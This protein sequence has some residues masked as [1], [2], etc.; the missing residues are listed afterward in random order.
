[1]ATTYG[2]NARKQIP[3]ITYPVT[4]VNV[5]EQ[6]GRLRVIYDN[7]EAEGGSPTDA[8]NTGATGTVIRMAKMPKGCR[9]WQV[10]VVADDIGTA[11]TLAVGDSTDPDRFI[12]ATV[13][14]AAGKVA[15]MWPKSEPSDAV[16]T[17]T[18]VNGL[19]TMGAMAGG[20]GIDA[21]GY[22]YTSETWIEGTIA[23]ATLANTIKWA[24]W[25]TLD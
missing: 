2:V 21:F 7:Y 5:A 4:N 13:L 3:S 10:V 22:E 9:V 14:G 11:G 8:N 12:I 16:L 1:M 24:V 23:T 25:Y 17:M 19:H 15:A 20:A 18:E 6:G